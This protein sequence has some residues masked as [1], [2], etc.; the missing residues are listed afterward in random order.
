MDQRG[1]NPSIH[2]FN[3]FSSQNHQERYAIISK[4]PIEAN[5]YVVFEDLRTLGIEKEVRRLTNGIE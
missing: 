5:M 2:P 3:Q 4:I 1:R